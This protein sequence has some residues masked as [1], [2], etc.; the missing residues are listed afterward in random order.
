[1]ANADEARR[2]LARRELARRHF[3]N[4]VLYTMPDYKMGWVHKE[5]CRILEQFLRDCIDK[6]RPRLMIT[7]PPR[8]GKSELVSRRFPSWVLG[9]C[10]DEQIIAA[11]YANTLAKRMNRDAQRI[12]DSPLYKNVFPCTALYGKK[13]KNE[14]G[15]ISLRNSEMFEIVGKKGSYRSAGV[16]NGI[17]G[18]GCGILIIDDPFKD[19]ADA[20]SQT[21]RDNV[22][23]WYSST[24]Y[25]RLSPGGG[26]LVTNTRW[27]EDD[28]SGRLIES[29]KAGGDQW[30]IINY[31]AIAEFDEPNRKAGEALHPERYPLQELE[32][33]RR[34]MGSYEWNAL[35]QQRPSAQEGTLIKRDWMRYYRQS[36]LPQSFDV[37][38]QS[39][40]LACTDG[41]DSDFVAGGVWGKKGADIWL[42]DIVHERL[43][44][45]DTVGAIVRMSAKWPQSNEKLVE[46]KAN[47]FA[48]VSV[49]KDKVP[50]LIPIIPKGDKTSRISAQTF[51]FEAGNVHIPEPSWVPAAGRYVE[52]LVS[53]GAGAAHDDLV[54]MTSQALERLSKFD[55]FRD[56][57]D[58]QSYFVHNRRVYPNGQHG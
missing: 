17:T 47:G 2:E 55:N 54:D 20:S 29:M 23:D 5:I 7:M 18:M 19:R 48:T 38:I 37:V 36:D 8:H 21:I 12:I 16:G 35:Y 42:L 13:A 33:I 10:P 30:T 43:S 56:V 6:K 3:E 50:G 11:S 34:T 53:F 1:M 51:W 45:I 28:L 39:W 31:P 32:S 40:D 26:V 49:L 44:F 27:H 4:F 52:E 58:V 25:T 15:S 24:A 41:K 46:Y 57:A 9:V 22:W 14:D